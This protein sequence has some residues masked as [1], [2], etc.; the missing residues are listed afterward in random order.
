MKLYSVFRFLT[1]ALPFELLVGFVGV[2]CSQDVPIVSTTVGMLKGFSPYP[3][4]NAYL[5]IPFAMPPIGNLRF[6]PPQ[7]LMT[8]H[9][10]VVD[11]TQYSSGCYQITLLSPFADKSPGTAESEDCLTMNVWKPAQQKQPLPVLIWLYGGGFTEGSNSEQ[12]YNGVTLVAEQNDII[13]ISIKC[14]SPPPSANI[15]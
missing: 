11:A 10:S 9:S 2:S 14:V 4:V 13:L 6:A 7:P 15:I 12:Q 5:G 1:I 8:N 3:K